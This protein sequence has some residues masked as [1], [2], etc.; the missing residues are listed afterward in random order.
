MTHANIAQAAPVRDEAVLGW[1]D[2]AQRGGASVAIVR[3]GAK[4]AQA[5][6]ISGVTT[7]RF[8]VPAATV[9]D[10]AGYW[11]LGRRA[12]FTLGVYNVGD[13][14]YWDYA[15]ARALAAATTVA[16]AND[17]ERM[18]RPGRYAAATLKIIY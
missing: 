14:K 3:N 16:A 1:D 7:A 11:N 17:I 18:A 15:S 5:D 9:V 8:A 13:K 6:V 10:L 4:T 2:P 12:V